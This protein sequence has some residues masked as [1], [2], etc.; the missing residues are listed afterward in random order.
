MTRLKNHDDTRSVL[1][2]IRGGSNSQV[3]LE[4]TGSGSDFTVHALATIAGEAHHVRLFTR[5]P[6]DRQPPALPIMLGFAMPAHAEMVSPIKPAAAT[7]ITL[8]NQIPRVQI[9]QSAEATD[10]KIESTGRVIA[11]DES[12]QLPR[13]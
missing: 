7:N 11:D 8:I 4:L 1:V 10:V 13:P 9:V 12:K 2:D 3:D 6:A 5:E